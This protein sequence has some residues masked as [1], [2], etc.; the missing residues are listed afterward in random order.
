[1]TDWWAK[2][3]SEGE[4]P[5]VTNFA[6]MARAQNDLYM[7]CPEGAIPVDGENTAEDFNAGKL[8]KSELI[9]N[10]GN[11]IEFLSKTNAKK[12]LEKTADTVEIVNRVVDGKNAV[13]VEL[14]LVLS[15][16]EQHHKTDGQAGQGLQDGVTGGGDLI[17]RQGLIEF[18]Y[19]TGHT[20]K[21]KNTEVI[22]N[23]AFFLAFFKG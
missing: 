17:K 8:L 16:E 20:I 18:R 10:A 1:M 11:I 2:I 7:T 19:D 13:P 22:E 4:E 15:Q 12:R 3:N 9:R 6:Q 21:G 5:R 23:I 14:A